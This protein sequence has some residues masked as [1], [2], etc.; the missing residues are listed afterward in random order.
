MIAVAFAEVVMGRGSQQKRN[1]E[2]THRITRIKV[3]RAFRPFCR[4]SKSPG[5]FRAFAFVEGAD[6]TTRSGS[7]SRKGI[8]ARVVQGFSFVLDAKKLK[9]TMC[10]AQYFGVRTI[11]EG[12]GGRALELKISF[13]E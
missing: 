12:N 10:F 9:G 3:Q 11:S 4:A 8:A 13:N 7:H 6:K 2:Q 5:S 1:G